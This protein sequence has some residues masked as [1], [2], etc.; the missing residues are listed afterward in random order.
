VIVFKSAIQNCTGF[1]LG[2][3]IITTDSANNNFSNSDLGLNW[4]VYVYSGDGGTVTSANKVGDIKITQKDNWIYAD[5][6]F[7][8]RKVY[9][10][11]FQSPRRADGSWSGYRCYVEIPKVYVK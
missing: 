4:P 2:L 8:A 11:L 5:I 7:S 10:I 3:K 6:T 1:T 9:W